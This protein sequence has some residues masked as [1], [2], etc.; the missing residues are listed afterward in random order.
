VAGFDESLPERV[1]RKS[2]QLSAGQQKVARYCVT[3]PT[4]AGTL[5]ALRIAE[6]LGVS[7]ST[8]VRFAIKMGYRGFPDMQAAIRR[9]SELRSV[10]EPT[11]A[12]GEAN[13]RALKSLREDLTALE[14]SIGAVDFAKF[15]SAADALSS[16]RRL[17]VCGF[18]SSFSLAYLAEFHIRQIHPSV[19]LID[20]IGGTYTDDLALIESSD[21][22]L[23]FTF[24]VY[25]ERT[26]AAV[27]HAVEVG[28]HAVV[29]TD[30]AL[31]PLPIDPRVHTF[32]VRHDSL[33]FF[34]SNVAATAL[35]N[36]FV[37]RLVELRS[38]ED[39]RFEQRLIARFQQRRAARR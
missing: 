38:R 1:R 27:E 6:A 31:A 23:A 12:H 7:E 14:E 17:Y 37:V 20:A 24:P 8:V 10:N 22:L 25:D 34:N 4:K 16:A 3:E 18:R 19:R 33:T 26:V 9:A 2:G 15:S 30:S 36:A 35:L 32:T 13:A 11:P 29:V 39:A 5:T 28:A 21:A